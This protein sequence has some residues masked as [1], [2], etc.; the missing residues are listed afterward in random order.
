MFE[1]SFGFLVVYLDKY[2][3]Q[4]HK[5]GYVYGRVF[6]LHS[7]APKQ[8]QQIGLQDNSSIAEDYYS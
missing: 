4:T 3:G 1:F 2:L 8:I 6:I 7:S 5:F